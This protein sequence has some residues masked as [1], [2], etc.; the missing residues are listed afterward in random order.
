MRF[1]FW[2][3]S[4]HP[5]SE[6]LALARHVES[7]GWDRMYFADHFM[8]NA[9][10]TSAPWAEAWTTLAGLAAAVPRIRFGT[11]VTGN[12]YRHPA[13]LAKMAATLDQLSGGRAVLGLGAGWQENE[14]TAYGI[15]F[16]TLRERLGRL[17]EACQVIRSLFENRETSFSG[18]YYQLDRAPLEPKPVQR[19]LPLLIGGGGEKVTLRIA[20]RHADEWNVWGD[21]A[22]LRHKMSVLDAHCRDAGRSPG[23]VQRSAVALLTLSDDPALVERARGS[24]RAR[25]VIAGNADEV[26]KIVAEYAAAGVDE[27]IVPDFNLGRPERSLPVLDRFIREIAPAAR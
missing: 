27:L 6:L 25:P 11:L 9:P 1:S 19:P 22:T 26:R 14:H 3:N 21:V 13:V 5:W 20:A 16:H 17:D 24:G 8:P 15:P 18:R 12:T 10:D 4:S 7:T 2:P 23:A